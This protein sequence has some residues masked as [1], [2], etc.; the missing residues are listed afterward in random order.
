MEDLAH[1]WA[2]KSDIQVPGGI[3]SSGLIMGNLGNDSLFSIALWGA[4]RKEEPKLRLEEVDSIYEAFLERSGD[5]QDLVEVLLEAYAR[6]RNPRYLKTL[7]EREA[8]KA[9]TPDAPG[10]GE[11]PPGEDM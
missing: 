5:R 10:P 3:I 7:Q 11:K 9:G 6:A 1:R 2:K 8:A 4:L